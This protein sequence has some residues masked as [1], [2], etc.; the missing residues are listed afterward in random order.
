MLHTC[1]SNYTVGRACEC[2]GHVTANRQRTRRAGGVGSSPA[3]CLLTVTPRLGPYTLFMLVP[4]SLMSKLSKSLSGLNYQSFTQHFMWDM[5]FR[6][7][8]STANNNF[9]LFTLFM[10]CVPKLGLILSLSAWHLKR[11]QRKNLYYSVCCLAQKGVGQYKKWLKTG[12]S[13]SLDNK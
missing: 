10:F 13:I 1:Q 6:S 7:S 2:Y 4:H 8:V 11:V 5:S 9:K 12:K 3:F